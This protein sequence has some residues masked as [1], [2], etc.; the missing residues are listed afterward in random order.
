[1][2]STYSTNLKIE[3]IG[4]GDQS[5]TWG[6]TTN[7]N[8]G[9]V[10]EEAIVGSTTIDFATNVDKT[11]TMGTGPSTSP[12]R[13]LYLN[14]TSSVSLTTTRTLTVPSINKTYIIKNSTTGSQSITITDGGTSTVTIPNGA[15]ALLYVD[16][17][18]GVVQQFSDLVSTTTIGGAVIASTTGTQTLTTKRIQPRIGTVASTSTITPTGDTVDQYNVTALAVPATV[19]APSGSPT[20]GQKLIIRILD[21]GTARAL[22]WTTTSGAYR[23]VGITLPTTTIVGKVLYIGCI[24]N[25]AAIYWDVIVSAQEA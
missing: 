11:I 15:T 21:N 17:G 9:T 7:G 2:T 1:M 23:P 10:L 25:S 4:N 3:L 13:C 19:A 16:V 20:D 14:L 22:T 12:T 6:T 24:Y 8:L 5:G 18:N